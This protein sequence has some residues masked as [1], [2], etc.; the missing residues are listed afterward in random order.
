MTRREGGCQRRERAK[1]KEGGKLMEV[2]LEKGKMEARG[3]KKRRPEKGKREAGGGREAGLKEGRK[4]GEGVIAAVGQEGG[5][6]LG[7][8]HVAGCAGGFQERS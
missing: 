7:N 8:H 3:G 1:L 6:V 2:R 5:R 4:L